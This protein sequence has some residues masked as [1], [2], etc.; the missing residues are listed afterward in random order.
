MDV[1]L[2][3]EVGGADVTP[4]VVIGLDLH[5]AAFEREATERIGIGCEAD[6]VES[7]LELGADAEH[8]GRQRLDVAIDTELDQELVRLEE[9]I[10]IIRKLI[11]YEDIYRSF[12]A[13]KFGGGGGHVIG[14]DGDMLF[15]RII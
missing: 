14:G 15:D 11:Y 4:I 6:A 8:D 2:D 9:E 10:K 3:V 13:I 1:E 7:E 5:G 12:F